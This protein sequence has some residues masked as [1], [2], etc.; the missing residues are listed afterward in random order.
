[1][2]SIGR[3]NGLNDINKP[4]FIFLL[5]RLTGWMEFYNY[6][7][8]EEGIGGGYR[9]WI[10]QE[11]CLDVLKKLSDEN[12]ELNINCECKL[13]NQIS[14]N[15]LETIRNLLQGKDVGGINIKEIQKYFSNQPEGAVLNAAKEMEEMQRYFQD[16]KNKS[17]WGKAGD[18]I[19]K[20]MGIQDKIQSEIEKMLPIKN[21]DQFTEAYKIAKDIESQEVDNIIDDYCDFNSDNFEEAYFKYMDECHIATFYCISRW[22][23][24]NDVVSR[25][26]KNVFVKNFFVSIAELLNIV[27]V[28]INWEQKAG[29]KPESKWYDMLYDELFI[30]DIN[31]VH[32]AKKFEAADFYDIWRN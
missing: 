27:S 13:K 26:Y 9:K 8:M 19:E 14:Q 21:Y 29:A 22:M 32:E 7:R 23:E 5:E 12:N 3:E 25:W 20:N 18:E 16:R 4:V 10:F 17:K 24:E 6:V 11:S 1:M 2:I 31:K 15:A 30:D 28:K